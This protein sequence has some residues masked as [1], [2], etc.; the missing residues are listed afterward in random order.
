MSTQ[1][2]WS[3]E[4][5]STCPVRPFCSVSIPSF[6]LATGSTADKV[7][8]WCWIWQFRGVKIWVLAALTCTWPSIRI[9]IPCSHLSAPSISICSGIRSPMVLSMMKRRTKEVTNAQ[10]MI[11]TIHN[12]WT[13]SSSHLPPFSTPY[14]LDKSSSLSVSTN[15]PTAMRPQM[16]EKAWV[17]M[18]PT[19][20]SMC[21][22]SMRD[23][24]LQEIPPPMNPMRRL[25]QGRTTAQ[26]AVWKG[27]KG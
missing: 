27:E 4:P 5:F 18:Q 10:A 1:F 8:R 26:M 21:K 20:S 13:P 7:W 6:S 23:I 3:S 15:S 25:S 24:P 11:T 14:S 2:V 22:R 12:S 19:G 16:D 17:G 9:S